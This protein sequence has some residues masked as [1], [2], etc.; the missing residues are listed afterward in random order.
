MVE[1]DRELE[2]RC[3]A[4]IVELHQFF[5]DWFSASDESSIDLDRVAEALAADFTMVGPDGRL[6]EAEELLAA[7]R[8]ARGSKPGL[9]IWI[10]RVRVLHRSGDMTVA[11]YEERQ[12]SEGGESRRVST[13]VF[14]DFEQNP[15]ALEWL[16][17]Q[18]KWL[19]RGQ[20]GG[21]RGISSPD[22]SAHFPPP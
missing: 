6:V 3:E 10:D 15:N 4:E 11:M 18:E 17:V 5:E 22:P 7:L 20:V 8:E 12:K 19:E 1:R 16:H 14:R 9:R 13:A 2:Q 21:Q